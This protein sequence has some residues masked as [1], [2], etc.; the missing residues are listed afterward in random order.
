MGE[1]GKKRMREMCY[2]KEKRMLGNRVKVKEKYCTV[3]V[4]KKREKWWEKERKKEKEEMCYRKVKRLLGK[5]VTI[6]ER[7]MC[8]NKEKVILQRK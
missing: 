2:K 8:Y 4:I 7:F 5:R 6:K 1:S 3:C